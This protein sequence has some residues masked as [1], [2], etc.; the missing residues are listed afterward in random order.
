ML[1][2]HVVIISWCISLIYSPLIWAMDLHT[3][4]LCSSH[5]LHF[6]ELFLMI[7]MFSPDGHSQRKF[8]H[9][10][11]LLSFSTYIQPEL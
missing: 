2:P 10:S 4:L 9:I 7:S 1:I 8:I 11:H 5:V 6:V 3:R